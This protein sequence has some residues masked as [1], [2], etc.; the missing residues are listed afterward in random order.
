MY[1]PGFRSAVTVDL[2]P[3]ETMGPMT[4]TPLPV[5]AM[6][7]GTDDGVVITIVTLPVG[8]SRLFVL[9]SRAPPEFASSWSVVSPVDCVA[10]ARSTAHARSGRAGC[11]GRGRGAAAATRSED[12]ERHEWDHQDRV[13][14]CH[15][16]SQDPCELGRGQ[17]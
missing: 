17:S 11:S 8:A 15:R 10:P 16:P 12:R 13:R 1:V 9:N 5:M 3:L 7:C 6:S 4:L 2:A 14:P